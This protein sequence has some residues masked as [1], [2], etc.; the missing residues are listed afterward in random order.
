MA[1]LMRAP[2][3]KITVT[4][5]QRGEMLALLRNHFKTL[6]NDL[7]EKVFPELLE[8]AG[9]SLCPHGVITLILGAIHENGG[10]M[11]HD[12]FVDEFIKALIV[13]PAQAEVTK[14]IY[15]EFLLRQPA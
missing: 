1:I 9:L 5:P 12:V 11:W 2:R 10:L 13:D 8:G 15:A 4:L 7:E 3:G 14:K 6:S